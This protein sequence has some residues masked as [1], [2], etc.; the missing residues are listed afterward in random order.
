MDWVDNSTDEDAEIVAAFIGQ[1]KTMSSTVLCFYNGPAPPK[2]NNPF[3]KLLSIPQT[4]NTL[5]TR[6]FYEQILAV[7]P[8]YA[9]TARQRFVSTFEI[10]W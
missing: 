10:V 6:G 3:S 1:N 2:K 5:G 7:S 4:S 9:N 8:P